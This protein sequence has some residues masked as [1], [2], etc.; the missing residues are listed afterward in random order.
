MSAAKSYARALYENAKENGTSSEVMDQIEKQMDFL[1]GVMAGS[2]ELRIALLGPITTVK[3]KISLIE[4]LS[5]KFEFSQQL[6]QFLVLLAKKGRL[7]VLTEIRDSFNSV[8]LN[9]EGGVAGKLVS[10][11]PMVEA[12]IDILAKA[13]SQKL[14]K[15]V[16]FRVS[17]DPSLLAGMKV[18]VNG[19]TYDGTLRSQL[20]K[21]RDCFVTGFPGAH[22]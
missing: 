7:P 9:L 15:K 12:D 3:E 10:A 22:V 13:F 20:Q 19:V 17:T 8:R 18:T 2:K 4:E 16:A 1:Q 11:E 5:K 21:L 14:G 6:S